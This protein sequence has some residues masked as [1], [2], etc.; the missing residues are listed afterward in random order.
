MSKDK[1]QDMSL[2]L[3]AKNS[4]KVLLKYYVNLKGNQI[5]Y[6]EEI[7][8][9]GKDFIFATGFDKS[10][11][12]W[13]LEIL[14]EHP[15][16]IC[17]GGGQFF[18][19]YRDV[20]Y[21]QEK[22][23]YRRMVNDVMDNGWFKGGAYVWLDEELI[24]MGAKKTIANSLLKY[25]TEKARY[26]GNKSITQDV[27][28]I[29]QIFPKSFIIPMVRDGRDVA[30]SFAFQF[31]RKGNPNT[32][33]DYGKIK[34]EYLELVSK[35]WGLYS[36]HLLEFIKL[37]DERFFHIKYEDL[38]ENSLI[39]LQLLFNK[40]NAKSSLTTINKIIRNT[41]FEV[42]SGGRSPGDENV[43]HHKRKGI[44]GDWKNHLGEREKDVFKKNCG[45]ELI[46]F[47]YERDDNW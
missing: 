45:N 29:R 38:K 28:L 35:A 14:N 30:V 12:T 40:L 2:K 44:I 41:T 9:E 32:F 47:G 5:R 22:G 17:R 26:I 20:Y 18:N 3:R 46:D 11:T 23:G 4:L 19:F 37:N 7:N 24:S 10:G 25:K 16:I 21:L 42:M 31:K 27:D 13:L 34:L 33:D 6:Y 39:V 43:N 15:E 8:L 1:R 36:R